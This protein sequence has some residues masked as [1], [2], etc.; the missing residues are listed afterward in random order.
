METN[1]V[2]RW[3]MKLTVR[4]AKLCYCARNVFP[5]PPS[6]KSYPFTLT[7]SLNLCIII[8]PF[9]VTFTFTL[10]TWNYLYM[11][12]VF[13]DFPSSNTLVTPLIP[14]RML[15]RLTFRLHFNSLTLILFILFSMML[16]LIIYLQLC[17]KLNFK[18]IIEKDFSHFFW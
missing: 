1:W 3:S 18:R 12:T 2:G 4:D 10:C 17:F 9:F 16:M 14:P 5:P 11:H 15:I 8:Y 6:S 7:F 13:V